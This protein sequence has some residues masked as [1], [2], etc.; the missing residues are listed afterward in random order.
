MANY[1]FIESRDPYECADCARLLDLVGGVRARNHAT[2][3]LLIQNGVLVARPG[4]L[5]GDRLSELARAGVAVLADAFSLR[6]RAIA[7][8]DVAKASA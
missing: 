3:L 2:T 7:S 1:L 4:A 6:E 8:A 5:H